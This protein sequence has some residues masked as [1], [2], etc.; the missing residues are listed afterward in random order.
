MTSD[1]F[2]Y[3]INWKSRGVHPGRHKSDQRGMGIEFA[4]HS[5]LLDYPDPR[6]IDLRMTMR[7]PMEQVY[8]RIFNQR[9][10]TPVMIFSDLSSSMRFG[11]DQNNKLIQASEIARIIKNSAYQNSD[12]IGFVGFHDEIEE[13]WIA[14]LSYRPYRVD[15]LVD[16]MKSFHSDKKGTK[17]I[18]RLPQF[19]PKYHTLIFFI[20]D[21]HMPNQDIIQFL[22]NTK[23]HTVV[24]IILWDK[25]EFSDLPKFGITTMTDPE[26]LEERTILIRKRLIKKII[27]QFENQ[28]KQLTEIFHRFDAPPFFIEE[29]FNPE[30][31][32]QY[33]NEYYHA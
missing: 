23:K 33:F 28:K 25:K 15:S 7:D 31:M 19:L 10:A 3:H 5:N 32:T 12:A 2:S 6:R 30:L 21:F 29:K 9:S 14:P 24:P 27:H 11:D 26:T 4:G 18:S 20:S 17:A 1:F 16:Q 8:V 13:K 22:N